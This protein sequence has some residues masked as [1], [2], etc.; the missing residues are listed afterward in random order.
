MIEL[1]L[2]IGVW[3]GGRGGGEPSR[4]AGV[5]G[6]V[7]GGAGGVRGGGGGKKEELQAIGIFGS[8]ADA[9]PPR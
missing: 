2:V 8:Y 9:G 7:G 3:G 1:N 5:G 6:G 4:P